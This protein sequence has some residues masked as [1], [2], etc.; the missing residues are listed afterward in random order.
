MFAE[1]LF[2]I[3]G[4][5]LVIFQGLISILL[6]DLCNL[7]GSPWC[8]CVRTC[9]GVSNFLLPH[10]LQP[11][12]FLCPWNIPGKNTGVGCHFLLQGIFSVGRQLLYHQR[13]LGSPFYMA[14]HILK[15]KP[16]PLLSQEEP[17]NNNQLQ[18]GEKGFPN[19]I[20]SLF[21]SG[22]VSRNFCS[23]HNLFTVQ[24]QGMTTHHT[25]AFNPL[26]LTSIE[27]T[28]HTHTQNNR[29]SFQTSSSSLLKIIFSSFATRPF[30]QAPKSGLCALTHGRWQLSSHRSCPPLIHV[31][32][33]D[34][35]PLPMMA[36]IMSLTQ[37]KKKKKSIGS[38]GLRNKYKI[39]IQ[40][41]KS[42][43]PSLSHLLFQQH[44]NDYLT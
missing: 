42:L 7:H 39:F 32:Y 16:K 41:T 25:P 18:S 22:E 15:K 20:S 8:V 11:T 21:C 33:H 1:N 9:S 27:T 12:R 17:N 24:Y 43:L 36:L 34:H 4:V 13:H 30:W 26:M 28:H 5:L 31:A 37:L 35:I 6:P 23:L 19:S 44:Y 38:Y 29:I 14:L 40:P 3:K 10:G 2:C